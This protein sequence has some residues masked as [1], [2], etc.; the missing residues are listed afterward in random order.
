MSELETLRWERDEART[1]A[2]DANNALFVASAKATMAE[3]SVRELVAVVREAI[4]WMGHAPFDP[5]VIRTLHA[6]RDRIDALLA[7]HGGA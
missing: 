3:R 2:H 7:K 6:C 4:P 1:R 5:D